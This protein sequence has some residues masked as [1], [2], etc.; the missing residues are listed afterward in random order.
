MTLPLNICQ[1]HEVKFPM[2]CNFVISRGTVTCLHAQKTFDIAAPVH[3]DAK[4]ALA[5]SDKPGCSEHHFKDIQNG[6]SCTTARDL[7][8]VCV[9]HYFRRGCCCCKSH[10]TTCGHRSAYSAFTICR[11]I[12][13][14]PILFF[15]YSL[16]F[17]RYITIH[18]RA[19]L[20]RNTNTLGEARGNDY[21]L[22]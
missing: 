2:S 12:A 22:N 19:L 15:K 9:F 3:T 4:C 5:F 14:W 13:V 20:P 8:L 1:F 17:R 6:P 16:I 18:T 7:S 10:R 11:S 21:V